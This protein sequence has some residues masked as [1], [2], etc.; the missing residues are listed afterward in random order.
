MS[1]YPNP[2]QQP[3]SQAPAPEG[4]TKIL[5]LIVSFIIPVAG[6][7]IGVIYL[8]RPDPAS[9][10]FG[11]QALIAALSFFGLFCLCFACYF[12]FMFVVG[13]LPFL[14]LPFVP[15]DSGSLLTLIRFM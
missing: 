7:I 8:Q 15:T 5:L 1:D 12:V 10:Q 4:G 14:F 6:I 9:Q 2:P 11:K 13:F 3:P